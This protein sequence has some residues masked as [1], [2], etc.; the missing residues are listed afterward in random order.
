MGLQKFETHGEIGWDSGMRH[1]PGVPGA[2]YAPWVVIEI[3]CIECSGSDD[4]RLIGIYPDEQS[5]LAHAEQASAWGPWNSDGEREKVSAPRRKV[6]AKW[7]SEGRDA[8]THVLPIRPD[9]VR[10][11]LDES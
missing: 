5:A 8:Q 10:G 6:G 2:A 9:A 4:L 11:W 3:R 7:V 1:P